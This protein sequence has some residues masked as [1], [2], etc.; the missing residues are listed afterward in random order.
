[1]EENQNVSNTN[2]QE[3]NAKTISIIAYITLIGWIVALVMQGN[4]NP[5][6][7][8]A[9]FH[10]R[11]SLGIMLTGLVGA[12]VLTLIPVIGWILL[13]LMY[14]FILIMWIMGLIAAANGEE[15]PV[16]LL[17][18]FYQKTFHGIQ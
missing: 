1:M 2:S 16:F 12:I 5:K 13:P 17:G 4:E 11:Q 15:K 3:G 18:A 6:S 10:L 8:L 9:G 14:I 7:K